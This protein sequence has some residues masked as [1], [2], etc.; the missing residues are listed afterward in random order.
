VPQG[1]LGDRLDVGRLDRG[2][3]LVGRPGASRPAQRQVGAE[4]LDV[5]RQA[6]LAQGM[7]HFPADGHPREQLLSLDD[8]LRLRRV[9]GLPGGGEAVGVG[10][11]GEAPPYRLGALGRVG[12][13]GDVHH[14]AEAV[15][16][17]RPQVALLRVHGA[18]QDEVRRVA[19]RQ[20]LALDPVDTAGSGIEED[21]HEV[22]GQQVNL[23]DVQ[24][25][26]VGRRQEAGLESAFATQ[27]LFQVQC[28]EH[29]VLGSAQ[30]QFDQRHRADDGRRLG[31]QRPVG[32]VLAGPALERTTGDG[33]DRRQQGGQGA[34]G[35]R[36]RYPLGAADEH[37]A[38]ARLDDA[39]QQRPLERLL[40]DDRRE[41]KTYSHDSDPAV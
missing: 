16:Q 38:Q 23:V 27:R 2:V 14:Q 32:D 37:A 21:V 17:L 20:P 35:R 12:E 10:L 30:R 24:D 41:R 5:G 3:A 39:Q 34:D 15:E 28:P 11:E 18:D 13:V 33:L 1:Q 6:A 25:A 26:A 19:Q 9:G 31:G 40:A 7:K 36:F 8:A 29:P 22:V 4:P